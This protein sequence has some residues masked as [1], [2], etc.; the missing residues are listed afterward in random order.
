MRSF[1]SMSISLEMHEGGQ[2]CNDLP[3]PPIDQLNQKGYQ[4]AIWLEYLT[5]GIEAGVEQWIV[6]L[7]LLSIGLTHGQ[8]FL[9]F[10]KHWAATEISSLNFHYKENL[11]HYFSIKLFHQISAEKKI[12]PWIWV[13]KFAPSPVT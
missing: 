13:K 3:L 5:V 8:L 11:T 4:H 9:S 12:L 7:C 10:K 2:W 1:L 6:Q